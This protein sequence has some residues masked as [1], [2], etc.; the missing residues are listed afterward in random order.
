LSPTALPDVTD[1][2]DLVH[3]LLHWPLKAVHAYFQSRSDETQAE[4]YGEHWLNLFILLESVKIKLK[5]HGLESWKNDVGPFEN[6]AAKKDKKE[7]KEKTEE[8]EDKMKKEQD[9]IPALGVVE[10]LLR[11][12]AEKPTL[13]SIG[14]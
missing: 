11:V 9:M 3:Y 4:A 7:Q 6:G 10:L 2:V 12:I 1:L 8:D 13:T 14:T 5:S